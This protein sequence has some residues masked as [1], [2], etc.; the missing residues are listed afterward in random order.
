MH[1]INSENEGP[2]L[3]KTPAVDTFGIRYKRSG[4]GWV[5]TKFTPDRYFSNNFCLVQSGVLAVFLDN[6]HRPKLLHPGRTWTKPHHPFAQPAVPEPRPTGAAQGL[7]QSGKKRLPPGL[8]RGR[9]GRRQGTDPGAGHGLP[10]SHPP[11]APRA[12]RSCTRPPGPDIGRGAC[13]LQAKP[14]PRGL[15][16]TLAAAII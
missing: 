13:A 14:R 2:S 15:T 6:N 4:P 7:G 12:G 9:G 10:A 16:F 5:E 3:I 8:R 1:V 11:S